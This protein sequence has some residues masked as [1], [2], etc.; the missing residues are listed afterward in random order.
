VISQLQGA[1]R[2][3]RPPWKH[4]QVHARLLGAAMPH[5][6][7]DHGKIDTAIHQVR[8]EGVAQRPGRD[9]RGKTGAADGGAY[10]LAYID[11]ADTPA[12]MRGTKERAALAMI[13]QIGEQLVVDPIWDGHDSRLIA[14]GLAHGELLA[15]THDI[16]DVKPA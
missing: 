14:L 3:L 16:S 15:L 11:R 12:Q 7:G 1:N 2:G 13:E 4:M 6:R 5:E 9:R 8:G 10:H